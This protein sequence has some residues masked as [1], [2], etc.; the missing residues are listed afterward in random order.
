MRVDD[1]V[2]WVDD[3]VV[4]WVDDDDVGWWMMLDGG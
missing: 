2:V 4:V 1:D 3:D